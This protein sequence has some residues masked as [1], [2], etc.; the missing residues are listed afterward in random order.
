VNATPIPAAHAE[1]ASVSRLELRTWVDSLA[2]CE[3]VHVQRCVDF[4]LAETQGLWHGRA[5]AA[6]CRR[7][8]HCN[9]GRSHRTALVSC[10]TERLESGR[11]SEQFK[12]QVRLALHLDERRTL[13]AARDAV[14]SSKPHVRRYAEWVLSLQ[15]SRGAL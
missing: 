15:A 7:L 4:V 3:P 5:R 14:K 13:A 12:D 2:S 9:L 6:M 8:K 1:F 11:F 10:I